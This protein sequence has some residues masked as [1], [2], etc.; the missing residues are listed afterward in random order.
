VSD[1]RR[2]YPEP[3]VFR[4]LVTKETDG[5]HVAYCA[6]ALEWCVTAQGDTPEAAK[7]SLAMLLV[8]NALCNPQGLIRA[9]DFVIE[10]YENKNAFEIDYGPGWGGAAIVERTTVRPRTSGWRVESDVFEWRSD[11]EYC[12]EHAAATARNRVTIEGQCPRSWRR[13]DYWLALTPGPLAEV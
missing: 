6:A 9:C 13:H 4:V 3:E 2:I 8:T 11:P 1:D 12:A 10:A 5:M 7:D